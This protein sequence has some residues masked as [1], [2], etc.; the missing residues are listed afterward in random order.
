MKIIKRFFYLFISTAILLPLSSPAFAE[1]SEVEKVKLAF[2]MNFTLHTYW[3]EEATA[4]GEILIC[5]RSKKLEPFAKNILTQRNATV[6]GAALRTVFVEDDALA[7]CDVV[8]P[9][10]ANMATK[11][12]SYKLFVA[13]NRRGMPTGAA[14]NLCIVDDNVRFEVNSSELERV[15]LSVSSK[16]LRL[17]KNH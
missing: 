13:D 8:Y 11:R 7:P 1:L 3:P 10:G 15:G 6:R 14:F 4:D 2:V 5:L 16:V 9:S 17:A 12:R